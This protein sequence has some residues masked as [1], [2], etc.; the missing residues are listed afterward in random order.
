[1][2]VV[3]VWNHTRGRR[4]KRTQSIREPT[5][6][7]IFTY[8]PAANC[9]FGD[10]HGASGACVKMNWPWGSVWRRVVVKVDTHAY[11]APSPLFIAVRSS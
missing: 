2:R 3:S 1:M 6:L 5:S 11:A 9:E 7:L 4:R 8:A 10:S